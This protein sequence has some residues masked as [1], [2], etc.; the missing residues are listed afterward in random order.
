MTETDPD[1]LD[2]V[3]H[4]FYGEGKQIPPKQHTSDLSWLTSG[5]GV[6]GHTMMQDK[7]FTTLLR[8]LSLADFLQLD[9]LKEEIHALL[10]SYL[11]E[12][13]LLAC[14]DWK[15]EDNPQPGQPDWL[16]DLLNALRCAYE[17][18]GCDLARTSLIAFL[19]VT[20]HRLSELDSV[21]G[22]LEE[23]PNISKDLIRVMGRGGFAVPPP[24]FHG[25]NTSLASTE[26][27]IHNSKDPREK[28]DEDFFIC[29]ECELDCACNVARVYNAFPVPSWGDDIGI[30][31]AVWCES[32]YEGMV[33]RGSFPWRGE[34]EEPEV[35]DSDS[36][37]W[38][39]S[40]ETSSWLG[41]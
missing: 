15:T 13:T 28:P 38:N 18:H 35:M 40:A 11:D 6:S 19:W 9:T 16:D 12:K 23:Q 20:R 34:Y 17:L 7:P 10:S 22:L 24:W 33:E 39:L 26:Y 36:G 25:L 14:G 27:A 3:L 37:S 29:A 4:H 8:L 32:C 30:G 21:C 5:P 41:F 1:L 31:G 2:L